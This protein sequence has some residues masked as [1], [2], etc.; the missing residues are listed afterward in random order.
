[1]SFAEYY[2]RFE[3]RYEP[4]IGRAVGYALLVHLVLL[5]ILF[6][7]VRWH[8]HR[9]TPMTVELFQAPPA[10][11]P[12]AKVA[13]PKPEPPRPEP[14]KPVPKVEPP[15]K[16]APKPEPKVEAKPEPRIDKPDIVEKAAPKPEPK[17]KPKPETTDE[18]LRRLDREAQQ[19][20]AAGNLE[21]GRK[22][23]LQAG[24]PGKAAQIEIDGK[25]VGVFGEL[26][27]LVKDK[28]EV[29]D[30]P[31]LD[32]HLGVWDELAGLHTDPRA[33]TDDQVGGL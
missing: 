33:M 26:H 1:M 32:G 15:P 5:G 7:G 16:P 10:T 2:D 25:V 13:P 12:V 23:F 6:V 8:S 27:P 21:A 22:L 17:P 4:G 24:R 30:A 3:E 18:R 14:P 31:I 19:H 28:Y 20:V 11:K 9:P 29:G